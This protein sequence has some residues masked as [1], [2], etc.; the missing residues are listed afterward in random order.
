MIVICF[1]SEGRLFLRPEM[2]DFAIPLFTRRASI[3]LSSRFVLAGRQVMEE[4]L[5]DGRL[6]V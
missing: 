3:R 4:F 2:S 5:A 6:L 1:R